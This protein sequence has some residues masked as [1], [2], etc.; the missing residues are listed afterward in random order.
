MSAVNIDAT[1]EPVS[2]STQPRVWKMT[3]LYPETGLQVGR[4][5][6]KTRG[7]VDVSWNTDQMNTSQ[8]GGN[9]YKISQKARSTN[10]VFYLQT[11]LLHHLRDSYSI[12]RKLVITGSYRGQGIDRC[13]FVFCHLLSR[14]WLN[15]FTAR[16]ICYKS[17]LALRPTSERRLSHIFG[18]T[19][20]SN[21]DVSFWVIIRFAVMQFGTYLDK[22]SVT[23]RHF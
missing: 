13:W 2:T 9:L 8:F 1:C 22:G 12:L 19:N 23:C 18:K 7:L 5:L 4:L 17:P 15:S 14:T 3:G 6:V 10:S 21:Y 11:Q 16:G 20:S